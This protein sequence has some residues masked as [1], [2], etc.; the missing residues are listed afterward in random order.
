MRHLP[1]S[2]PQPC[3]A[4]AAKLAEI[5]LSEQPDIDFYNL[6]TALIEDLITNPTP[7]YDDNGSGKAEMPLPEAVAGEEQR[8]DKSITNILAQSV[9]AQQ[10]GRDYWR[11][12]NYEA[13]QA[14]ESATMAIETLAIAPNPAQELVTVAWKVPVNNTAQLLIY[15][16]MGRVVLQRAVNGRAANVGIGNLANGLYICQVTENGVIKASGKVTIIK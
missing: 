12:P 14:G 10:Q 3:A 5:P 13:K 11:S 2:L 6:F 15:D 7:E 1:I 8:N 16:Y 9:A 4:A